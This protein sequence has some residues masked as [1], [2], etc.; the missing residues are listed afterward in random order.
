MHSVDTYY[1][2]DLGVP[3][4]L[5][6]FIYIVSLVIVLVLIWLK[7]TSGL[8]DSR[9]VPQI[10]LEIVRL[11]MPT[12]N[13]ASGDIECDGRS[14]DKEFFAVIT[15]II[16]PFFSA[17]C[18]IT[19]FNGYLIHAA[20]GDCLQGFDCFPKV[21]GEFIHRHP[22]SSC[23]EAELN[24]LLNASLFPDQDVD[25]IAN[26]FD[27]INAT[28]ETVVDSTAAKVHFECYRFAFSYVDGIGAVG[29][30]IIFAS[31][32][33]T[34]YFGLLVSIRNGITDNSDDCLCRCRLVLY[35]IVWGTAL[36]LCILFITVN[37]S[38]EMIRDAIF[39][40]NTDI[41]QFSMYSAMFM[42]IVVSGFFIVLAIEND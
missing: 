33:S 26:L 8:D 17:A 16:V 29:G 6:V 37:P 14:M 25:N 12:I 32:L 20:V 40:T 10:L 24:N 28:N 34:L 38:V 41:I 13:N 19:F 3:L 9:V 18:F 15:A 23:S 2:W 4:G 30:L 11:F 31:L 5:S 7:R 36:T 22:V 27:D 35:C 42:A 1:T 39:K 21:G